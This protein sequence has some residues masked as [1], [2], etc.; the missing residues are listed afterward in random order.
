MV[1]ALVSAIPGLLNVLLLQFFCFFTI[2]ILG[3]SMF[4]GSVYKS[5]R[6]TE[7]LLFYD[8]VNSQEL[9]RPVWPLAE[10]KN[11]LLSSQCHLDSDCAWKVADGQPAICGSS[12]DKAELDPFIVDN[13]TDNEELLFGVPGFDNTLQGLSTIFQIVT[14]ESWVY[15]MYS[16]NET[17]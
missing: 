6:S 15:M 2:A 17:N 10:L 13:V 9:T 14:L 7:T 1:N 8:A 3:V 12:W 11:D 16:Y 5:C 4:S